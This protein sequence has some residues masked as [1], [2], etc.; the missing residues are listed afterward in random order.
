M[1]SQTGSIYRNLVT[2]LYFEG[3]RSIKKR[4]KTDCNVQLRKECKIALQI[5][6]SKKIKLSTFHLDCNHGTK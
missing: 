2:E 3:L 4:S 1:G 6:S 5:I